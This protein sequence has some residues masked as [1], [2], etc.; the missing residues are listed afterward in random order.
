MS[1]NVLSYNGFP[2]CYRNMIFQTIKP[3]IKVLEK[4][5]LFSRDDEVVV[6]V[7]ATLDVVLP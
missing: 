4:P 3:M 1:A 5:L 7:V 2:R 6:P